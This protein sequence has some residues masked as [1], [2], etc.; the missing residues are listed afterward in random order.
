MVS[1][2]IVLSSNESKFKTD[3]YP[4]IQ[5][6]N[7]YFHS[8]ALLSLDMYNS[9]P[10]IHSN[11]NNFT[12]EYNNTKYSVILPEGSYEIDDI[13]D[14][15]QNKLIENGHDGIFK[16]FANLNTLKC[17]IEITDIHTKIHFNHKTSMRHL[18]GFANGIIEG[19]KIHESINIVQI[20]SVN[21]ILVHCNII[22][23]SY[24]NK[25]QK[26][27]LYSF[28]PNVPAGYKIVQS[29]SSLV[30]LPINVPVIHELKVW[31]TD[32]NQNPINHRGEEITI[33]M[34]LKSVK[35]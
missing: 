32:Q 14:Y 13:N 1:K 7:D 24:L 15:I 11:N 12:Y 27:I 22:G 34:E 19:V 21:S 5:L 4:P 35:K 28:S 25:Y 3:F 20:Y 18:L 6:D 31:L 10:N 33:R 16:I 9:I 26:P 2:S 29:P 23:E 17:N 30:Y 8:L